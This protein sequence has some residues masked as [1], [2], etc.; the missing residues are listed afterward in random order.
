MLRHVHSLTTLSGLSNLCEAFACI[1][2]DC[3]SLC[4]VQRKKSNACFQSLALLPYTARKC[5]VEITVDIKK[6][7][8]STPVHE[9]L[10][11]ELKGP[12]QLFFQITVE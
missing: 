5:E 3:I 11:K 12:K 2:C 7:I 9:K 10:N 8:M 4:G 1:P 6:E